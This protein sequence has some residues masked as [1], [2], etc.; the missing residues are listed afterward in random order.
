MALLAHVFAPSLAG[1]GALLD[2]VP[3]WAVAAIAVLEAANILAGAQKW[4]IALACHNP[5]APRPGLWESFVATALGGVF[6][7]VLPAQASAAVARTLLQRRHA[8]TAMTVWATLHEQLFDLLALC[9]LGAAAA[10][11]LLLGLSTGLALMVG[12]AVGAVALLGARACFRVAAA[13]AGLV[14]RRG[15][16][17]GVMAR[18]SAG[19]LRETASISW[20][21]AAW[22]FGLSLI[23]TGC[24]AGRTLVAVTV[25]LPE[26]PAMLVLAVWPASQLAMVTPFLPGG[27]GALE[28]LWAGAFT[29]AGIA[30]GRAAEAALG[31]RAL[32]LAGFGLL[33]S[34]LGAAWIARL[35]FRQRIERDKSG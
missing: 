8:G 2:A 28:W 11:S 9:A 22:L 3:L 19:V 18:R 24:M 23:R 12:A 15:G 14:A 4:R 7:Q 17:I 20:R 35:S 31:M 16:P 6:A 21:A 33:V 27:F 30:P 5:Q 13:A 25:L 29:A 32:M 34:S 26:M 10:F 1:L